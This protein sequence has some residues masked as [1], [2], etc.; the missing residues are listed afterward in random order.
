MLRNL[1]VE[2]TKRVGVSP[3][4][5]SAIHKH[6]SLLEPMLLRL[7]S[8][9]PPRQAEHI[10]QVE[11]T[12]ALVVRG[13]LSPAKVATERGDFWILC[14]FLG[15]VRGSLVHRAGSIRVFR[16]RRL[17]AEVALLSPPC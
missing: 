6:C 5:H 7:S 17:Q 4:I 15:R 12:G 9:A 16:R 11:F 3:Q 8:C 14:G 2:N 1:Q 10:K 13:A